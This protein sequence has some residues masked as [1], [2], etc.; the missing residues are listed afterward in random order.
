MGYEPQ[1]LDLLRMAIEAACAGLRPLT[2]ADPAAAPASTAVR[3]AAVL[4]GDTWLARLAAIRACVAL[5][6]YRP[7]ALDGGE[8][9]NY[10]LVDRPGWRYSTDPGSPS[11]PSTPAE[12][13]TLATRLSGD[14]EPF[15]DSEDERRLLA[16]MLRSIAASPELLAEFRD[17]FTGWV[18]LADRLADVRLGA[19]LELPVGTGEQAVRQ[20]LGPIDA[21]LAALAAVLP[22]GDRAVELLTT[23]NYYSATHVIT[24]LQLDGERLGTV[25]AHIVGESTLLGG[26][27]VGQLAHPDSTDTLFR[28]V[29]DTPGAATALLIRTAEAPER[30]WLTAVDRSLPAA[31]L[32][33]GSQRADMRPADAETVLAAHLRW[34]T[35][36]EGR[37][38][39]ADHRASLAAAVVPW[40]A[41]FSPTNDDWRGVGRDERRELLAVVVDDPAAAE[42]LLAGVGAQLAPALDPD[43]GGLR[44]WVTD[45]AAIVGLMGALDLDAR[46]DDAVRREQQWNLLTSVA[47]ATIETVLAAVGP[48][49]WAAQLVATGGVLLA[50]Q[51]LATS[52]WITGSVTAAAEVTERN[53]HRKVLVG[54]TVLHAYVLAAR[55]VG[56]VPGAL[57][58]PP[59]P[60]AVSDDDEMLDWHAE[61]MA[62]LDDQRW[63]LDEAVEG[64]MRHIVLSFVNPADAAEHYAAG[65]R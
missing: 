43:A 6:D 44:Q 28:Q 15:T 5:V 16:A 23:M 45:L 60:P 7:S 57:P 14:V 31:V 3:R 48:P 32:V 27:L 12:A 49:G 64:D 46:V 38:T 29:V 56:A 17:H 65:Q 54:A 18:E 19:A 52:G 10:L 30:L 47:G 22:T 35:T 20:Q 8:L 34:S 63:R 25:A 51:T 53:G 58:D 61:A 37:V 36:D 1:R 39:V 33:A 40:L 13:H 11:L 59:T 42:V 62:W 50:E 55:R 4:L 24:R 26:P 21:V 41:Q 2:S 9:G